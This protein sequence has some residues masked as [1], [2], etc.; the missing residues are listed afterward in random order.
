MADVRTIEPGKYNFNLAEALKKMPEFEKPEWIAFVKTGGDK[1]RPNIDPD[2]WYKRAAAI[3][4]Q[5][6]I[7]GTVGVNRL[8]T[9]FGGRK[10]RG[11]RPAEFRPAGGK[12]IRKILQQSEK[13]GF[14][15]KS[16]TKKAGRILTLKGREFMESLAK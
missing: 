14:M 5:A 4:R 16:K 15:E 3:L 8:R 10:N 7:R 9:R 12:I 1:Q 13:A 6:Y 11:M 2:F